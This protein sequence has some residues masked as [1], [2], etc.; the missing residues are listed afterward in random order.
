MVSVNECQE[1]V[2]VSWSFFFNKAITVKCGSW[3]SG[4]Q[5][6]CETHEQEFAKRYPQG[7]RGY[8]GDICKHGVYVGGSG[9]DYMCGRCEMGWD[10]LPPAMTK[11]E[12]RQRIIDA[13]D[14]DM[15]LFNMSAEQ[16]LPAMEEVLQALR[17][18]VS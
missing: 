18:N 15:V 3:W 13:L 12:I 8:P 16:M 4:E 9:A 6:F 14:A 11:D 10:D 2:E 5:K 7:W 1:Q 17:E